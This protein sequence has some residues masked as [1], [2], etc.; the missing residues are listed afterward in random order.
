MSEETVQCLC[1]PPSRGRTRGRLRQDPAEKR[2]NAPNELLGSLIAS[3]LKKT[4]FCCQ[5][6]EIQRCGV[7]EAQGGGC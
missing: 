7:L 3:V 1:N 2:N 6:S 4:E 5:L